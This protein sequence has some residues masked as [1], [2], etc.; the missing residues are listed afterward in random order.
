MEGIKHYK[1]VLNG[2]RV[3]CFLGYV[4][5]ISHYGA[6]ISPAFGPKD[7]DKAVQEAQESGPVV[8]TIPGK[9]DTDKYIAALRAYQFNAIRKPLAN[10]PFKHAKSNIAWL[11][12]VMSGGYCVT[13]FASKPGWEFAWPKMLGYDAACELWQASKD[14]AL[15]HYNLATTAHQRAA[16]I[17]RLLG[18]TVKK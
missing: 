3:M 9:E 15:K 17:F 10:E 12:S 8:L 6:K 11:E 13:N 1:E 7:F 4:P 14:H 16:S 2:S 18:I 5:P